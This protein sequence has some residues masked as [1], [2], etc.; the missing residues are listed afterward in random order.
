VQGIRQFR[1]PFRRTDSDA[2]FPAGFA[3]NE[4]AGRFTDR[5]LVGDKGQQ[6]LVGFAVDRRGLD[7]ELQPFAVQSR[8]FILAG[9]GLDMEA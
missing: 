2:F 4:F 3:G 8:P 6:M 5:K 7:S 1:Q 9:L